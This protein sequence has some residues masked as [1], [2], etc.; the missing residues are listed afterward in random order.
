MGKLVSS[1]IMVLALVLGAQAQTT[2]A[3]APDADELT[4]LLTEF[5][6]GASRNDA[7]VHDR[8]WAEDVIYTG[9]G[10]RRRGKA[11][12]MRDVRAA[13][14]PKPGD[15]TT[16]YSAE[17]IRIQQ[18]GNTAVVA[19]RLIGTTENNGLIEIAKFLNSGTFL[20]RKGKWQVVNWQATKMPRPAEEGKKEVAVIES[21]FHQAILAADVKKLESLL[22]ESFIWTH[23]TGQQTTRQ[24]LLDDLGSSQLKYVKLETNNVT[25]NLYGESAV[26][27]GTST[28]QYAPA[29]A[30]PSVKPPPWTLFYTLTFVNKDGAWKAVAMHTS[31]V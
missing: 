22:D 11:E 27:R 24:Q 31:W 17:E 8:F 13:P 30:S 21:A 14:A 10:G 25:V 15:S 23:R 12:I 26:V 18:Y 20:K 28:R 19:F 5:L 16:T 9:S 2:Q 4:K 29:L 6:A 3:M 7:A 1:A